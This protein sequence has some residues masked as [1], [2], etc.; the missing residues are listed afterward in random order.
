VIEKAQ[1]IAQKGM[2][3][4]EDLHAPENAAHVA[5]RLVTAGRGDPPSEP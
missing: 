4:S 2:R 3:W 1:A 5:A